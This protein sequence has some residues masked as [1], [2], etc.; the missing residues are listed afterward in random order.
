YKTHNIENEKTGSNLPFVFNDVIG[1]EKGSGKG[2]H[3]DDIIKALKGHV[4][5]GYKFNMNY[6]LSEEDNGYKKSPSS[7]DRAHC[8]VSPIPADTFTLMDDD[9]IKKM[10]AIR[11]VASDMGFPQVVILT[12]VDMACPMGNKNLRN[13]YKSKY[14]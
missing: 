4:K 10:R 5:E 6:P 2:V 13:G 11:L 1:L 3:E 14:I 7:S 12:H 9:V 8:L